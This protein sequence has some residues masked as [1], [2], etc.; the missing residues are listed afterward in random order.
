MQRIFLFSLLACLSMLASAEPE[1]YIIDGAHTYPSFSYNHLGFSNQTHRFTKTS[2]TITLDRIV[3]AGSAEVVVDAK[4]VD[5]GNELFNQVIQNE[6]FLDTA[7]YPAITYK[8]ARMRFAGDR[9]V[10]VE[11][12]LT[13]KGV[14][15]P[16]E[17]EVISLHCKSH[18]LRQR[19]AC[20]AN[21][22]ARIKRSEFNMG[23]YVPYVGDEIT[24]SIPVE[25][26]N[27]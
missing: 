25:A 11:G 7:H 4:S 27:E 13:I 6:D 17:L 3:G 18:P 23:K 19:N 24:L 10:A 12:E 2:G 15:R 1:T 5:T 20:G 8:S 16:V 26:I 21:A 22:T 14:T 9:L